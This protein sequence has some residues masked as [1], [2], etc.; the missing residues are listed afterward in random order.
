LMME[1][2]QQGGVRLYS[3]RNYVTLSAR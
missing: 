2:A 1:G 3:G